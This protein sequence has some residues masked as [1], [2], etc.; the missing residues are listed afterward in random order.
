MD[1]LTSQQSEL[2]QC[3]AK[4]AMSFQDLSVEEQS[5]AKF[6]SKL[7]YIK[8]SQSW[9]HDPETSF[10]ISAKSVL[11]DMTITE[12]GKQYLLFEEISIKQF[13]NYERQLQSLRDLADTAIKDSASAEKNAKT[14]KKLSIIAIVIS[15][16]AIAVQALISLLLQKQL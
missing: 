5:I 4:K 9:E 11:K 7:E 15:I 3:I 6:L 12:K 13:E 14:S 10:M 2:L 1:R 8:I 16:V